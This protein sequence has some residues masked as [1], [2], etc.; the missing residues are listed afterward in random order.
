M[1]AFIT[2]II[3]SLLILVGSALGQSSVT[4]ES[5]TNLLHDSVLTG[6]SHTITLRYNLAGA[7]VGR[8]YLTSNGFKIYSPDGADWVSVQGAA[9]APF[10]GVGWDNV[11]VNHFRKTGGTGNFGLPLSVAGGNES[12]RDTAVVLL[13][14]IN[15][16]TGRGLP[17]GFNN[18]TLSIMF[19]TRRGDG[20]LHL[21]IDTCMQAPGATW[22]WANSDGLIEPTWSGPRCF[23]INCCTGRTGD[24]NAEG[25]DE[26]TIGDIALLIG[27][28]FMS[29]H[30]PDCLGESDVNLSGIN[31]YPPQDWEDVTIGD[32]AL[33]IDYL[34][35]S[36]P[37]L[38]D[39]P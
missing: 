31:Q 29:D 36:H 24:V 25:G 26:P 30:Q 14:G 34:F 19:N 35:I 20:G 32:I 18:L 3:C 13:A 1:K 38:P 12:G 17:A 9:L 22:E 21:C 15:G 23:L 37:V 33:L 27:Y 10:T 4:I 6:G 28:L 2:S 16:E 5:I 11:F 39:C 7:P 8:K